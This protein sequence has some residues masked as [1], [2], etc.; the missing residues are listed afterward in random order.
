[1]GARLLAALDL[2]LSATELVITPG[3][4]SSEMRQAAAR[5][6]SPNMLVAGPWAN[7]ALLA[8]KDSQ[9]GGGSRAFV[10]K[11]MAC[12]PPIDTPTALLEHLAALK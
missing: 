9:P 5:S 3:S 11:G 7:E 2:Y 8:G 10:C 4:G 6:F 12:S 1:M